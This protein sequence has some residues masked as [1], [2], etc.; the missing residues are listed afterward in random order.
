MNKYSGMI[1]VIGLLYFNHIEAENEENASD[2]T[3]LDFLDYSKEHLKKIKF[4]PHE[5]RLIN[6]KKDMEE[7]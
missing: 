3:I 4:Y 5:Y 7:K 2:K 1:K 6:A